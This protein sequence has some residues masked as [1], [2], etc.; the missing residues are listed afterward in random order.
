M[1]R[2]ASRAAVASLRAQRTPSVE[3][4]RRAWLGGAA[5]AAGPTDSPLVQQIQRLGASPLLQRLGSVGAIGATGPSPAGP[6]SPG[7]SLQPSGAEAVPLSLLGLCFGLKPE[8]EEAVCAAFAAAG[9]A[10]LPAATSG[11]QVVEVVEVGG[12][13]VEGGGEAEGAQS[14][15]VSG[16]CTRAVSAGAEA[17]AEAGAEAEAEAGAEA[18][19]EAARSAAEEARAAEEA[20]PFQ[21]NF[22][23]ACHRARIEAEARAAAALLEA[24]R[25]IDLPRD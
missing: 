23:A 1:L 17:E 5:A 10:I 8:Q 3:A 4:V 7:A 6:S 11:G 20:P 14:T 13:V 16:A 12:Q 18:E 2:A 19:A 21:S 22:E 24:P 15:A 9:E 25:S